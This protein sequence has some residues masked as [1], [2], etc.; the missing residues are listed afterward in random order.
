[1]Y[2]WRLYDGGGRLHGRELEQRSHNERPTC[3]VTLRTSARLPRPRQHRERDAVNVNP[4]EVIV[5]GPPSCAEPRRRMP[6]LPS[7]ADVSVECSRTKSVSASD[8]R[9]PRRAR[10]LE[11]FQSVS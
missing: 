1:M 3:E 4:A 2:A 8:A 6:E 9:P 10:H 7:P 5:T 11:P